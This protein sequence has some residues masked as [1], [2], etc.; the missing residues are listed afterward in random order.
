MPSHKLVLVQISDEVSHKFPAFQQL[1]S[2][3]IVKIP[4]KPSTQ[5]YIDTSEQPRGHGLQ[6][7]L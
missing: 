3:A 4:N 2:D 1:Y 6:G 7:S 5:L